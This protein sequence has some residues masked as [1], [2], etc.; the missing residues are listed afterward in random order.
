M[1]EAKWSPMGFHSFQPKA[2]RKKEKPRRATILTHIDREGPGRLMALA[3]R[4]GL[5]VEIRRVAQGDPVPVSLAPDELLVVMGGPMGVADLGDPRYP[6]LG[7]EV[8]LLEGALASQQPV[9]GICLGAQLL[10]F[11]AGSRVFPLTR[12]EP[13]GGRTPAREVGF[14]PVR[15]LGGD[16]ELALLGLRR[17]E[18]VLH[19]HG[20]TFDLPAGSVRLAETDACSNQAF[21]IGDHAFGLQFHAEVDADMVRRWAKEDADF[22]VAALG[23]GGPARI[24]AEAEQ[25]VSRMRTPGDRLL[26]NIL[27]CLMTHG[28]G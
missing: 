15:Y 28:A 16:C 11:A 24:I 3:G 25:A 6:Y 2:S 13:A 21:R 10:A 14:A 9:L 17:E 23:A 5:A 20:D 1:G 4:R 7:S 18:V 27:D 22:V 19:W 8:I 12:A 26:D